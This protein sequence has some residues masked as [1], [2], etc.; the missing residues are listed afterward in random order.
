MTHNCYGG[1]VNGLGGNRWMTC[2]ECDG[3]I[4][5]QECTSKVNP[6]KDC[7][8]QRHIKMGKDPKTA[9][10]RQPETLS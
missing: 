10:D 8:P 5:S 2:T 3:R 9:Q 1:R 4:H 7:C 6:K